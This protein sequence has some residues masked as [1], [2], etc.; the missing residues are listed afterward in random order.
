[1]VSRQPSSA[2]WRAVAKPSLEV[3]P[4][5]SAIDC[6]MGVAVVKSEVRFVGPREARTCFPI[7]NCLVVYSCD[8]ECQGVLN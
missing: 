3:V 7:T 6:S 1:M 8:R 2:S 4:V 5:T